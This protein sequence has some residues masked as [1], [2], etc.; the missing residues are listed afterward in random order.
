MKR[1]VVTMKKVLISVEGKISNIN[2]AVKTNNIE[3]ADIYKKELTN[4]L[5]GIKYKLRDFSTKDMNFL[6]DGLKSLSSKI[7]DINYKPNYDIC[8]SNLVACVINQSLDRVINGI[9]RRIKLFRDYD[10]NIENMGIG[11][12]EFY[13]T[14]GEKIRK[15][16]KQ[17]IANLEQARSGL[18]YQKEH[19]A[20]TGGTKGIDELI[21]QVKDNIDIES[22][23]DQRSILLPDGKNGFVV[24]VYL[25]QKQVERIEKRLTMKDINEVVKLREI[26]RGVKRNISK[27][28]VD[29]NGNDMGCIIS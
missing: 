21:K 11:V 13:G 8:V 5:I 25:K 29:K 27:E 1:M 20:Q 28:S 23:D 26:Q 24:N 9:N 15:R 22:L 19:I 2:D 10:I 4:E 7:E 16:D 14:N 17:K 12:K 18:L 3:F 6:L